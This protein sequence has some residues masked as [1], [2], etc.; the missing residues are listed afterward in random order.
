M[1]SKRKEIKLLRALFAFSEDRGGRMN[2]G[3]IVISGIDQ[4]GGLR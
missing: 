2:M 1:S 4:D 3:M